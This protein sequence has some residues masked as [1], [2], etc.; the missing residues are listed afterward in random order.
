MNLFHNF[1]NT[2][3]DSP[4]RKQ[5]GIYSSTTYTIPMKNGKSKF[6]YKIV[7]LDVRYSKDPPHSS[8]KTKMPPPVDTSLDGDG[9]FLG[10]EQWA[11][12]ERELHDDSEPDLFI[13]G[14]GLQILPTDKIVQESWNDFPAARE[15]LLQLV[16]KSNLPNVVLL[17]G[18]IHSA[19]VN[20]ARCWP[21]EVAKES[22][23]YSSSIEET[24]MD[25]STKS[26]GDGQRRATMLWELTSSGLTHTF[27]KHSCSQGDTLRRLKAEGVENAEEAALYPDIVN[28]GW[29]YQAAY[30]LVQVL[31]LYGI[32]SYHRGLF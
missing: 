7:L 5:E 23:E 16:L 21:K 31:V 19:E 8:S 11:W 26:R 4:K 15:R 28:K 20:R 32:Y 27:T 25:E 22:N 14:S 3:H 10:E 17:S 2:P 1:I 12:L 24:T 13:I 29:F 18:D 6:T 30:D 9:D